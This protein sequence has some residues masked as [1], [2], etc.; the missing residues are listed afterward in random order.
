MHSD[1]S[2]RGRSSWFAAAL[3]LLSWASLTSATPTAAPGAAL[4]IRVEDPWIRWLPAGVPAAGYFTL[5]NTGDESVA[6]IAAASADFGDV[7]IHRSVGREGVM[8]MEEVREIIVDPH[9]RLELAAKG[10]HLMLMNPV[11]PI[12]SEKRI[13]ISLRFRDGTSL[14][15]PF[16]VRKP[17]A[18]S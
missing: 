8:Q 1:S 5:I 13:P 7:S 4:S 3:A 15:V 10:Y 9:S 11:R 6:L 18:G 2:H 14:T 16:E 12:E 17:G